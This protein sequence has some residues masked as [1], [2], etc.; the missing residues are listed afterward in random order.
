MKNGHRT[1]RLSVAFVLA[2]TLLILLAWSLTACQ[3]P[4]REALPRLLAVI[5]MPNDVGGGT[6]RGVVHPSGWAYIVN[7]A[8][9][10][11]VVDGP[12]LI[13]LMPWPGGRPAAW[14]HTDLAVNP[15]N[16]YVY[17]PD[18]VMSTVHVVSETDVIATIPVS[19]YQP[20]RVAIHPHNGYVYVPAP[21]PRGSSKR[22]TVTVISGTTVITHIQIGVVPQVVA[23]NPVD[24][25][26]YV[27]QTRPSSDKPAKMLAIIKGTELVTQTNLGLDIYGSITDIAVNPNTGEMYMIPNYGTLIY[28]DGAQDVR[29][30]D[31]YR[32]GGYSL[33][34]V[35]VDTKRNW[36]YVTS[37]EGPPSHVAVVKKDKVIA[38][39]EV[40]G[41]D[42]RDVVYDATHDYVYVANRLSG[43]MSIIRGTEVVTTVSMG[44]M[45][46]TYITVDEKRGYI[47][48]S[49]ATSHS[50]AVFGYESES[51]EKSAWKRFLPFMRR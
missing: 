5:E 25:N 44:G 20:S 19:G 41:Y 14:T 34:N 22:G 51:N 32:H 38:D 29:M 42:L 4:G 47:Y 33:N 43:S 26:V 28:W 30:I 46:P 21:G 18:G 37:W 10:I 2:F 50:V 1:I 35:A 31:M 48:V 7:D 11:A 8:G 6:A 27:G 40:P 24:G 16:G 13:K 49:N 39:I 3:G 36:A 9:S 15:L 17:V 23:I 12:R 45:G